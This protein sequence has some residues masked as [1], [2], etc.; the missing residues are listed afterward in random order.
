MEV[1]ITEIRRVVNYSKSAQSIN[2]S[3]KTLGLSWKFTLN[4]DGPNLN[5]LFYF[6]K[7]LKGLGY[8]QSVGLI[9]FLKI[10]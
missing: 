2:L 6:L 8:G 7:E 3:K 4:T 1:Y 9:L 5:P 10:P